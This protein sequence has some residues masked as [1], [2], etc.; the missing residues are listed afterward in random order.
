MLAASD[1]SL[2]SMRLQPTA[3]TLRS[4][5]VIGVLWLTALTVCG[6]VPATTE[7]ATARVP[8]STNY[9]AN[10][11]ALR[12]QIRINP[13]DV[14]AARSLA[15]LLERSGRTRAALAVRRSLLARSRE[16]KTLTQLKLELATALVE[17]GQNEEAIALLKAAL[18]LHPSDEPTVFELG[19]ALA[20]EQEF[21][22]AAAAFQEAARLEPNDAEAQLSTAKVLVTLLRYAEAEPYLDAATRDGRQD[23]DTESLRGL[24]CSHTDR[25]A[26]ATE[27]FAAAVRQKPGDAE[28]QLRLGEALRAEG[29]PLDAIDPLRRSAALQPSVSAYF[30]LSKSYRDLGRSAEAQRA[31]ESLKS[32]EDQRAVATRVEV[33]RGEAERDAAAMHYRQAA[34]KYEA[35]L[36]LRRPDADLLY[37]LALVHGQMHEPELEEQLLKEALAQSPLLVGALTQLGVLE[38]SQM[39]TVEAKQHL[40][41]ALHLDPQQSEALGGLGVLAARDGDFASAEMLL[42]DAVDSDP[43]SAELRRNLGLV[44]AGEG[45]FPEAESSLLQSH[46]LAPNVLQTELALGQLYLVQKKYAAALQPLRSATELQPHAAEAFLDLAQALYFLGETERAVGAETLGLALIPAAEVVKRQ[47]QLCLSL[48]GSPQFE[49]NQSECEKASAASASTP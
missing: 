10:E 36:Q 20:H 6:Q 31:S 1:V 4:F 45:H 8:G 34:E 43:S 14:A 13:S 2:E 49:R 11:A 7:A 33:L 37:R 16:P 22:A 19:T 30:Q 12:E 35:A 38:A 3:I 39:K 17:A 44:Y 42:R 25:K 18:A 9:R 40:T 24:I 15:D 26:Q 23:F 21:V 41:E 27:A 32:L 47:S 29:R 5:G 46:V 28:A 48:T